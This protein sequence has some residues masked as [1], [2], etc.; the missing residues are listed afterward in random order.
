MAHCALG[1]YDLNHMEPA[2][3]SPTLIDVLGLTPQGVRRLAKGEALFH[4][5]DPVAG[6]YFIRE[7]EVRM[8]RHLAD[9]AAVTLYVGQPGQ[10]FAEASLF[11][12]AYHC[13]A[14]ADTDARVDVFAKTRV[15]DA[16]QNRTDVALDFMAHLAHQVQGLRAQAELMHIRSAPDRVL[17]YIRTRV[18][19]GRLET[20]IERP[21]MAI[22]AEI[23]LTHEAVYRALA[24]LERDGRIRRAGAKITLT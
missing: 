6:F 8:T 2:H 16:L 3:P 4:T 1:V 23:G 17:A 5:G 21:W 13:D 11:S 14:I 19:A 7:G 10:T 24:K 15:L 9:G 20:A 12:P 18:P 22:A